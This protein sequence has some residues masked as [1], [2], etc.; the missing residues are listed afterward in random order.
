MFPSA[1]LAFLAAS[2]LAWMAGKSSDFVKFVK[3][4]LILYAAMILI[5]FFLFR[6]PDVKET[7][8]ECELMLLAAPSLH[9]PVP[10]RIQ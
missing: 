3:V 2:L 6:N 9:S 5:R 1:T 7:F 8:P 4:D 10:L